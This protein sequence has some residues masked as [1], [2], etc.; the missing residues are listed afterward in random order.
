M[1]PQV[2]PLTTPHK[3][4]AKK[5]HFDIFYALTDE[6]AAVKGIP[7]FWLQCMVNHPLLGQLVEDG[8]HEA[9]ASLLDIRVEYNETYSSFKIIFTFGE[10]DFFTN[11]EL[12][13]TYEVAPDLLDDKAPALTNGALHSCCNNISSYSPWLILY[14]CCFIQQWMAPRSTGSPRRTCAQRRS[15]RRPRPAPVTR[16]ARRE[17]R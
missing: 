4:T 6:A 10:N 11:T 1:P 2:C 5:Q 3:P 13:K 17:D 15:A 14:V 8:D 7:N 12:V 9:L 16:A